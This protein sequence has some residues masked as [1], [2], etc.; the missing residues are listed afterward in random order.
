MSNIILEKN[1][2]RLIAQAHALEFDKVFEVYI[3]VNSFDK[4]L[5]MINNKE[6]R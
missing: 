6:V 1:L 5:Q 3:Q 4:L 2:C